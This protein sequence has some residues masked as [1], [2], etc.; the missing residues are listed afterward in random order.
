LL[1]KIGCCITNVIIFENEIEEKT[2]EKFKKK[3]SKND[4][5]TKTGSEK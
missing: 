2:K 4:V 1:L 5:D 3:E